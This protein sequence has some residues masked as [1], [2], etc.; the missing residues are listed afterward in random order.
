MILARG[1]RG[2]PFGRALALGVV[3]AA[4]GQGSPEGLPAAQ[5]DDRIVLG[6]DRDD[7]DVDGRPDAEQDVVAPSTDLFELALPK[8][9][10]RTIEVRGDVARLLVDGRP[11]AGSVIPAGAKRVALQAVRAGRGEVKAFGRTRTIAAIDVLPI[12]GQG[13]RVDPARSHASLERTPPERLPADPYAKST[14]PDAVRFVVVATRED[15]PP[16]V[17]VTGR[18]PSGAIVDR[19]EPLML[20][21]VACP[22]GVDA[23]LAC[24]STAPIR[25][26]PD[27]IDRNHPTVRDRSVRAELGGAVE[28]A[29]ISDVRKLGG[30]RVAGPRASPL[31]PLVR[32]R[33]VLR[34]FL[35]RPRPG[36]P[37]PVGG[38]DAGA[39]VLARADVAQASTLWGACGVSFGPPAE[40]EITIVD[41]PRPHLVALGCD[42]GLP[43][44]GGGKVRVR[45]D[46]REIAVT[47]EKGTAPA[48]AARVLATAIASA[49]FVA[50][51]S[52]NATIAA[53]ARGSSD[54]LVRRKSGEPALVEPPA[55][56]PVSTDAL[57]TACIG[58]VEL[59]DGLQHFN[60]IDAIAGTV[61]ERALIKALDDGDP[62]TIE[63]IVVPSFAGSG[64]IGESFIGADGGAVRNVLIT[65]RAALRA[66][67]ASFALAHELGHVLLDDPGHPDDFGRDTPTRLMDADAANGTAFGPRRLLVDECARALRQ[68]GPMAAVPLLRPWPLAPLGKER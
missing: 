29:L 39:M 50:R 14:N 48:G 31:G 52:D 20:G 53:G 59:E 6:V 13:Q 22:D 61:E 26:V 40:T 23:S 38:D 56:G 36:G 60:D 41:P 66:D 11:F 30:L 17:R 18:A 49:G 51:V 65:D 64:R 44:A 62:S 5:A 7:D 32:Y 25:V 37:P 63:V 16:V 33:G 27:E 9:K 34:V 68:S 8:G 28:L 42:H 3:L 35:V 2:R 19:L 12:D 54:V 46:G 4:A 57:L 58:R 43:A 21:A 10:D 15:L 1:E 67:R 55:S 47:M 24:A 45:V